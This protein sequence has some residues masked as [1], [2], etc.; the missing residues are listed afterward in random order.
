MLKAIDPDYYSPAFYTPHPGSDL[1]D[2]CKEHDLSLITDHDS[3]RRNPTEAKIKGHD[4]DFLVWAAGE[5]QRRTRLNYLKRFGRE[6][7]RQY[8]SPRKAVRK[9]RRIFFGTPDERR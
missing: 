4:L 5:S 7:V 2:Y 9:L 6:K 3:Y 8:A 1:F